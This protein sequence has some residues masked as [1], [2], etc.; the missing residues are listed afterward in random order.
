VAIVAARW[1][2]E[3]QEALV[4]NAVA[5][6]AEAGIEPRVIWVPGTFEIPAVV[7][8]LAERGSNGRAGYDAVIALGTV[9]RGGTPHF[10]YV[11]DS[12]THALTLVPLETG[13][14]VGFG[15]LTCDDDAQAY[16]R[17]GLPGSRENKGREAA[18]AALATATIL[19]RL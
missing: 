12:V 9:V 5:R 2:T 10:E 11:C 17:S 18:E 13:V 1:H 3:V 16:D 7:R 6:C 8:R 15:I 19:A 4:A 14:A